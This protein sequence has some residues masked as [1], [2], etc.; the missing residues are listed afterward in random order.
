MTSWR[1]NF[2]GVGV[3]ESKKRV[4]RKIL[5]ESLQQI[6]ITAHCCPDRNQGPTTY[7]LLLLPTTTTDYL[8]PTAYLRPTIYRRLAD[9]ASCCLL[10]ATY[11]L[12]A[13]NILLIPTAA[14][15]RRSAIYYFSSKNQPLPTRIL[16]K[17]YLSRTDLR[18]VRDKYYF[19]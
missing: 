5:P 14:H 7:N 15:D 19:D 11:F 17:K 2:S 18:P 3:S 8:P 12:S 9:T 10:L 6:L 4:L 13:Y 1:F 16:I